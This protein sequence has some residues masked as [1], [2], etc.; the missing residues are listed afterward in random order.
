M[1][2]A[3]KQELKK[4]ILQHPK[5]RRKHRLDKKHFYSKSLKR[6]ELKL[7]DKQKILSTENSKKLKKNL[8]KFDLKTMLNK[9]QFFLS[10]P[11]DRRSNI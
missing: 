8:Y 3:L 1:Q 2:R 9:R 6:N 10:K 5:E 7:N 11:N 4:K